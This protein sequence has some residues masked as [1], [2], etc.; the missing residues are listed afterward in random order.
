MFVLLY[1]TALA[2][3]RSKELLHR[4]MVFCYNDEHTV[5]YESTKN[6]RGIFMKRRK[7]NRRTNQVAKEI[8]QWILTL[9]AAFFIAF[10]TD[11]FLIV[12]AQIPSG[13]M[14]STIMPGDRVFGS[15]LSYLLSNPERFDIVIFR[16]PDDRS[17]LFIKRVIGLPGETIE[18]R[19]GNIYINGSS[20]P[21][22]DVETKEEMNGTFG[23]YVV[24]KGCYFML[25]DNRNN[26][27]DSRYWNDP[28]VP[29]NDMLGK[30][31]FR[32]WP[33]DECKLLN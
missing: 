12:N 1:H 28:F 27:K 23:P 4:R 11:H 2:N 19:N 6:E 25:G 30:A 17:Q 31:F 5:L 22:E 18:I 3:A 14:E 15:R 16:Y 29:L 26:S 33:L 21:L 24:P 32:Y 7:K 20:T 9:A 8:L 13:S 10:V